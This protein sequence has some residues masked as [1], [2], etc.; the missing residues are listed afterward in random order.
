MEF[1][2]W[3]VFRFGTTLFNLPRPLRMGFFSWLRLFIF[4]LSLTFFLKWGRPNLCIKMMHMAVLLL[5]FEWV[6]ELITNQESSMVDTKINHKKQNYGCQW[7]IIYSDP[8]IKPTSEPA[9]EIPCDHVQTVAPRLHGSSLLLCLDIRPR[10]DP[11]YGEGKNCQKEWDFCL[12]KIKSLRTFH[13]T[14][15]MAQ[16]PTLI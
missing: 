9:V 2:I 1:C 15:T 14:H 7:Y 16:T 11:M 6:Q 5:H 12:L 10:A 13:I 8:M 3:Y 4:S